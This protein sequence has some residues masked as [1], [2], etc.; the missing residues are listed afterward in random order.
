MIQSAISTE[1]FQVS[2][3][4]IARFLLPGFLSLVGAYFG[5]QF[6]LRRFKRERAF[7]RRVDWYQRAM[8]QLAVFR[9]QL[10]ESAMH[11][12][13]GRIDQLVAVSAEI[14][15][16]KN[17]IRIIVAEAWLFAYPDTLDATLGAARLIAALQ[18]PD[19]GAP[20]SGFERLDAALG[21]ID[22]IVIALDRAVDRIAKDFRAHLGI[23]RLLTSVA[24]VS[25]N[26]SSRAGTA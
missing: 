26:Q 23:E 16:G 20:A 7:D 17:E 15:S 11:A 2:L 12:R 5:A 24:G 18:P 9:G 3:L 1:A 14:H 6:A 25:T 8:R 4:E 13:A 22:A 21:D 10:F 19:A